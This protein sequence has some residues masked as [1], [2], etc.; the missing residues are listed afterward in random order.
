MQEHHLTVER[1][2][3]Y[4]TLGDA[5]TA[6]E[7]WIVIHGYGHLAR[8]FLRGF[9]GVHEGRYIVAPE[10]LSRFYTGTDFTRVGASWMTREDREHEILDQHHYLNALKS[11]LLQAAP[12]IEHLGVLGF[13]QG[14]A[15][16]ARWLHHGRSK[17]DQLVI[18][19]GSMP[20]EFDRAQLKRQW[21]GLRIDLVHGEEDELVGI[22]KLNGNEALLRASGLPFRTHRFPGGHVLDSVTLERV[23]E[24]ARTTS[25]SID[26]DK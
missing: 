18:W 26:R 13:S 9:E 20:P 5:A 10:A 3:R 6:K 22:A 11:H 8:Y 4:H 24:G 14:V 23:L 1:T 16:A 17:V 2:A 12:L 15:T 7:L 19:S 21:D 25:G